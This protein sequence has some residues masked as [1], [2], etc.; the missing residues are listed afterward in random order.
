LLKI[1]KIDTAAF[2]TNTTSDIRAP[3]FQ[4]LPPTMFG[5]QHLRLGPYRRIAR[6]YALKQ[7][8][9]GKNSLDRVIERQ[10]ERH[11]KLTN[12]LF[13]LDEDAQ[14]REEIYLS[15]ILGLNLEW[16]L[17]NEPRLMVP[18]AIVR[19]PK[20]IDEMT[21]EAAIR[22][23]SFTKTE[24]AQLFDALGFPPYLR[25]GT[26]HPFRVDSEFV[27]LW[28]LC[29]LR[30][31]YGIL[32]NEQ[33]DY[34]YDYSSLSKIFSAFTHY[35]DSNFSYLL[36]SI[37][38]CFE[39]G[40]PARFHTSLIEK[41]RGE[42]GREE[43]PNEA[44]QIA[45]FMDNSRLPIPRPG[46]SISLLQL[47]LSTFMVARALFSFF[48]SLYVYIF[49]SHAFGFLC[50]N[51]KIK[52]CGTMPSMGTTWL[53]YLWSEWMESFTISFAARRADTTTAHSFEKAAS[54]QF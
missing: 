12:A 23:T 51:G 19:V 10:L 15:L 27:F 7:R 37:P 28:G 9:A 22:L 43:V 25:C 5:A 42:D 46:V 3:T 8:A 50:R 49:Y 53:P 31:E 52:S 11:L 6:E 48:L 29:R 54:T 40:M 30:S 2:T 20:H 32:Y 33:S 24:L 44:H 1:R 36:S 47:F 38:W 13:L 16:A 21:E 35:I 41:L 45:F 26:T 39:E 17:L 14:D 34:G 4:W 18:D